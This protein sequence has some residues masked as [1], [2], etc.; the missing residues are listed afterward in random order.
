MK[1]KNEKSYYIILGGFVWG[2][3]DYRD[4]EFDGNFNPSGRTG[5]T[6]GRFLILN[7]SDCILN[8]ELCAVPH[9]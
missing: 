4:G 9:L 2:L 7:K 6:E 5:L 3:R 8:V 1:I